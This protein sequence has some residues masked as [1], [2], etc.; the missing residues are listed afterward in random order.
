MKSATVDAE[1]Q[2]NGGE[3]APGN[4]M[5]TPP[6]SKPPNQ[7]PSSQSNHHFSSSQ[8]NLKRK[9]KKKKLAGVA[10][11]VRS[12]KEREYYNWS[13]HYTAKPWVHPEPVSKTSKKPPYIKYPLVGTPKGP[14]ID[15]DQERLEELERRIRKAARRIC[16]AGWIESDEEEDEQLLLPP[17]FGSIEVRSSCID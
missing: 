7:N 4:P 14:K 13:G 11:E 3:S 10:A 17:P 2:E 6:T 9:K 1:K 16:G 12:T 15:M 5:L 8:R